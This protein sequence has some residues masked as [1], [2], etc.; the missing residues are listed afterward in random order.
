MKAIHH[1]DGNPNNNDLANLRVVEIAATNVEEFFETWW[2]EQTRK[3]DPA[4]RANLASD[5]FS[6]GFR[7]GVERFKEWVET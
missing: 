2:R 7:L 4:R 1:I 5:A 6:A 3:G